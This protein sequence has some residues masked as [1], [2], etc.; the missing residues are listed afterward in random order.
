[1]DQNIGFE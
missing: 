1:M